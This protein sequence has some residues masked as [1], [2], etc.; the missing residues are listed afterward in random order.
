MANIADDERKVVVTDAKG[1]FLS[2]AVRMVKWAVAAIPALIIL[3]VLGAVA[4]AVIAA[5]FG[6]VMPGWVMNRWW[7]R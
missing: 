1:P 7:L 5:L 6:G 2:V 4:S 3:L